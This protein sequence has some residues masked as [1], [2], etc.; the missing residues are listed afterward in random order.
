[1]YNAS[2]LFAILSA[3]M[4]FTCLVVTKTDVGKLCSVLVLQCAWMIILFA[5][6]RYLGI[7]L[8]G[9]DAP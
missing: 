1:M 9:K 7:R 5:E 8:Q 2:I 4:G 3:F 6:I